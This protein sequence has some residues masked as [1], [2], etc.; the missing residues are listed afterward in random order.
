MTSSCPPHWYGDLERDSHLFAVHFPALTASV[1][2]LTGA[3]D[4]LVGG[5][6]AS[7]SATGCC[8]LFLLWWFT[9]FA[10]GFHWFLLPLVLACLLRI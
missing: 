10:A 5:T 2:R 4:Y 3:G 9:Q 8:T 7:L 6:L 1:V